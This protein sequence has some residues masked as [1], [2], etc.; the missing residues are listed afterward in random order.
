MEEWEGA[1]EALGIETTWMVLQC[2]ANPGPGC[3][4]KILADL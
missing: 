4:I 2:L 3:T 1:L